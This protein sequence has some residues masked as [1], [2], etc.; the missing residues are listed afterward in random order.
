MFFC[1]AIRY[2]IEAKWRKTPK[3]ITTLGL[4]GGLFSNQNPNF[5]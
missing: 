3:E 4:P 5:G 2:N 1:T